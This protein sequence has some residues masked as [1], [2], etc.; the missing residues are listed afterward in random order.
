MLNEHAMS[1]IEK[2]TTF[3]RCCEKQFDECV[4][5]QNNVDAKAKFDQM[6]QPRTFKEADKTAFERGPTTIEKV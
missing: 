6:Q 3:P 2:N 1:K 5:D 4:C